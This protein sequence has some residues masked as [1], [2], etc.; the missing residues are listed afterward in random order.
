M[1]EKN[2]LVAQNESQAH[3]VKAKIVGKDMCNSGDLG[4]EEIWN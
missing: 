3:L 2:E 1:Q 4:F